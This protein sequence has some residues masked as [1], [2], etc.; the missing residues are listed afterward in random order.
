MPHAEAELP[1][2][3]MDI[4]RGMSPEEA[5][6]FAA[7][8][9]RLELPAGGPLFAEG[10]RGDRMY[11]LARGEV[12]IS[13]RIP[14]KEGRTRRLATYGPGVVLGEMAVLEGQ[15]RS[16]DAIALTDCTLLVLDAESLLAMRREAPALHSRFALN[17]A[18]QVAVRLRAT[19]LE[20]R[21]AHG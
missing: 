1:L 11:L 5:A 15:S 8:L 2:A 4:C 10:D 19:T 6:A 16:A 18:R 9:A 14:G 12:T 13:V 20:L 3:A 7:Y 21:V 17:L